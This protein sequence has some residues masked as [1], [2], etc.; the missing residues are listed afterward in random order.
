MKKFFIQQHLQTKYPAHGGIGNKD[1]E[2]VLLKNG[3]IPLLFP[4][5]KD[6]SLYAK[7]KRFLF[8][9]QILVKIPTGSILLFESPLYAKL[10]MILVKWI[11]LYKPSV[12]MICFITDINGLKDDNQTLLEN[13]KIFFKKLKYFIVHNNRMK[14]WL[15][16]FHNN[17]HISCIEFFD[18]LTSSSANFPKKANEVTFAGNL[19]KSRF[20][21]EL[22]II[23]GIQFH[24]YGKLDRTIKVPAKAEYYG[25]VEP[26][27]LPN[28]IKGSYGLVWDGDSVERSTGTFGNYLHYISPHKLSLYIISGLPL[29]AH[30]TSAS[31]ELIKKYKIGL[32]TNSLK[33]LHNLLNKVTDE[34]YNDMQRNCKELTLNISS[35]TCLTKAIAELEIL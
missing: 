25:I 10:Y 32:L 27:S 28:Q 7:A 3:F 23:E 9:V 1:V 20:I 8:L 21:N 31:A 17:A 2:K 22:D 15:L 6:F 33:E 19:F 13:E 16:S 34:E 5:Q 30:S 35:G 18:F 4:H 14:T 24:I 12:R 11:L 26:Y 29:I